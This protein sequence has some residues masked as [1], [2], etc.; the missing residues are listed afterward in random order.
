MECPITSFNSRGYSKMFF[1][2]QAIYILDDKSYKLKHRIANGS[3][4]GMQGLY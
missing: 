4:S 3:L 2:L 1:C